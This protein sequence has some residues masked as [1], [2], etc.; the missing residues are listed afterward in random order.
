MSNAASDS[1]ARMTIEIP[2]SQPM[3]ALL[4]SND[5]YLRLIENAFPSVSVLVRGNEMD[6]CVGH[7]RCVSRSDR[8]QLSDRVTRRLGVARPAGPLHRTGEGP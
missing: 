8:E 2:N 4:G 3:V 5:E 1:D 7:D 6:A